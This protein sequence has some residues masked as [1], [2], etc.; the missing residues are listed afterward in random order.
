MIY[1]MNV[2][3]NDYYFNNYLV[4]KIHIINRYKYIYNTNNY[5]E[6]YNE[7]I[8]RIEKFIGESNFPLNINYRV[9]IL[10]KHFECANVSKINAI[11]N[12]ITNYFTL[13]NNKYIPTDNDIIEIVNFINQNWENAEQSC[14]NAETEAMKNLM[15]GKEKP[16]IN[17]ESNCNIH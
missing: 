6:L 5:M 16:N 1:I 9:M 17:I 14:Y 2:N 13:K 8:N 3:L 11:S 7:Q 10:P 15:S 12:W 4:N